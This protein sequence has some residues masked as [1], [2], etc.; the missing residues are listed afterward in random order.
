MFEHDPARV[1][2]RFTVIPRSKFPS[3]LNAQACHERRQGGVGYRS[4]LNVDKL[5]HGCGGQ[6][7]VLEYF[8]TRRKGGKTATCNS[9]GRRS[10]SIGDVRFPSGIRFF[11]RLLPF[12]T[13]SKGSIAAFRCANFAVI[14]RAPARFRAGPLGSL[15]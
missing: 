5:G 15:D 4:H 10:S 11:A 2:V 14:S 6:F 12:V 3:W 9:S 7:H 8:M 13:V 1:F